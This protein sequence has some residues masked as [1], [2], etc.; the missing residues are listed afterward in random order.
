EAYRD[1]ERIVFKVT[2]RP[3]ISSIEFDATKDIQDE[4]RSVRWN[5]QNIRPG[6]PLDITVLDS[7]EQGLI[8]CFHSLGKNN[9][10]IDLE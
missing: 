1:G 5:Q 9:A 4:Q 3:T 10:K 8:D 6:E 2:E 7:V